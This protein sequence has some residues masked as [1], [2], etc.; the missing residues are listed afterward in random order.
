MVFESEAAKICLHV[1]PL[2]DKGKSFADESLSSNGK[3]Y[4]I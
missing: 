3:D 4:T 2:D 1:S